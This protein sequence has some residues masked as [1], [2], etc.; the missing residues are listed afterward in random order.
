[1]SIAS[2]ARPERSRRC[3]R[4]K[5]SASPAITTSDAATGGPAARASRGS[6]HHSASAAPGSTTAPEASRVI[7]SETQRRAADKS[8]TK[9]RPSA[10]ARLP[11]TAEAGSRARWR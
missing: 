5:T 7:P 4:P 1:M 6:S 10:P 8:P 11:S 3:S 2:R 9:R